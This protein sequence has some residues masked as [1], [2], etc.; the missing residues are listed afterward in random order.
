MNVERA[1]YISETFTTGF[2]GDIK[3][4]EK[5][6][7]KVAKATE[8]KETNQKKNPSQQ[9]KMGGEF[10]LFNFQTSPLLQVKDTSVGSAMQ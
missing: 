7:G 2:K 6:Q 3:K 5:V 4:F 8:W 9:Q 1:T 10:Y